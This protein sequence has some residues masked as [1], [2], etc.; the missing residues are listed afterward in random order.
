M[1]GLVAREQQL[2]IVAFQNADNLYKTAT[3]NFVHR[4]D[5]Y[6]VLFA[7]SGM[8]KRYD[9]VLVTE[10]YA[11]MSYPVVMS[12]AGEYDNIAWPGILER[13]FFADVN[14]VARR[15][16]DI[17]IKVFKNVVYKARAVEANQGVGGRRTIRHTNQGLRKLYNA[18]AGKAIR[19]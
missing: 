17:N 11:Y 8:D 9:P 7:G 5:G 10:H 15:T 14:K 19:G 6:T 2:L 12:W 4:R 1:V 16:R 3:V 18:V 13:Y